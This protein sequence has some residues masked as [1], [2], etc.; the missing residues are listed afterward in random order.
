MEG[1]TIRLQGERAQWRVKRAETFDEMAL[2]HLRD[3]QAAGSS[4][5]LQAAWEMVEE[6]W[7]LKKRNPDEL[8]LQRSIVRVRRFC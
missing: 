4:A 5:R 1:E 2:Q 8:R 6:A 3:W 7:R